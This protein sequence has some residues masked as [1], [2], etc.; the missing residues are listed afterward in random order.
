MMRKSLWVFFLCVGLSVPVWAQDSGP[1]GIHD[2][3]E[4]FDDAFQSLKE[5]RDALRS[6][7]EKLKLEQRALLDGAGARVEAVEDEKRKYS[8]ALS[9]AEEKIFYLEE[10]KKGLAE[11]LEDS[12]YASEKTGDITNAKDS[13]IA[14]LKDENAR[15]SQSRAEAESALQKAALRIQKLQTEKESLLDETDTLREERKRILFGYDDD[16]KVIQ[17]ERDRLTARLKALQEKLASYEEKVNGVDKREEALRQKHKEELSR[18]KAEQKAA[19]EVAAGQKEAV[20]EATQKAKL[21][22]NRAVDLESRNKIGEQ[23]LTL[24]NEK[25]KVYEERLAGLQKE[26][27]VLIQKRKDDALAASRLTKGLTEKLKR[28]QGAE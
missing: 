9:T 14:E 19:Q 23:K 24:A 22:G 10:E 7:I 3:L 1:S 26:R 13:S 28:C 15:L 18:L 21:A 2:T 27:E 6:E 4:N 17:E 25:L 12:Q 5:E 8:E 16:L 20:A 11:K